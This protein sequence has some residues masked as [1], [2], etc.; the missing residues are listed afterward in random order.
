MWKGEVLSVVGG[1]E[2]RAVASD[3]HDAV[4]RVLI[5]AHVGVEVVRHRGACDPVRCSL[6]PTLF[7]RFLELSVQ[8]PGARVPG[9]LIQPEQAVENVQRKDHGSR[10]VAEVAQD[11]D[12]DRLTG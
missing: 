12:T 7:H 5:V 6:P 9:D 8:L 4:A 3:G 1:F 2:R 11:D 10:I